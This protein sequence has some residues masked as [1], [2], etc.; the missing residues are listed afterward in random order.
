MQVFNVFV[1]SAALA[2]SYSIIRYLRNGR[3]P[4]LPPGPKGLP[5]LGNLRDLPTGG[6]MEAHHWL[7]HKQLYGP[8][9][10]VTTMGQP[11][12]IINDADTAFQLLEKRSVKYSS[13]PRQIV[14]G[15]IIG[16]QHAVGGSPNNARWRTMRKNM[17]R[18]MGTKATAA[19]FHKLQEAGVGHFLLHLLDTPEQFLDHIKRQTGTSILKIAY[20]YVAESH[21]MDH[22]I[23]IVGEAMEHFA[24]ATVPGAFMVDIFPWLRFVPE[25]M[26]GVGWK[27]V[28]RKWQA[29]LVEVTD[30]PYSFTKYQMSRGEHETSFLSRLL[31]AG[32][33][34]DEE[35]DTNKW[36]AMSLYAAGAET[37]EAALSAFYLA[38]TVSP[39]VQRIAQEE[40]DRVVGRDRLPTMADRDDLPYVDALVKEVY[41][42]YTVV[43]MGLPHSTTEDDI[44]E[45][46]F[47]PKGSFV[48]ANVWHFTHDPD[49]HPDPMAFK[50]ERYLD[51]KGH[52]PERDP[53]LFMW[54]FGRRICPGRILADNLIWLTIAQ[55]LSVYDVSRAMENGKEI[56]PPVLFQPGAVSH[57]APFKSVIKPRSTHHENLIKSIEKTY[58]WQESHGKVLESIV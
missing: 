24:Y 26:P 45:G 18:I 40:I 50:P 2:I 15:E 20:G 25:W 42:W 31:E 16:W 51:T 56:T 38:L 5:I 58:P 27:S 14:A 9:S 17:S 54:G 33:S 1:L 43:P 41:R 52:K 21:G 35:K 48:F 28:A 46:Y 34:T 53:H 19:Q 55:S 39:D 22:L 32:D 3:R 13:R 57:P 7:K 11:I 8:I 30:K 12:I 23:K 4:P 49:A 10:S 29:E 44:Y 6:G 37:T 47:I 36:S